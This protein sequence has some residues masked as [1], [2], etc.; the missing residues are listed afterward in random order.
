MILEFGLTVRR[1]ES[2]FYCFE[3]S[4]I[5]SFHDKNHC[6]LDPSALI[7]SCIVFCPSIKEKCFA[8]CL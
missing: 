5:T 1:L 4:V 8:F 7:L 2:N 6:Y 3:F